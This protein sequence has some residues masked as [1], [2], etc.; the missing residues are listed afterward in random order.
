MASGY[1]FAPPPAA[2]TS[3]RRRRHEL[4]P[5][6]LSTTLS[7]IQRF[8][9]H[10]TGHTP[11][12]S[13]TPT[14]ASN[15][16]QP[17]NFVASPSAVVQSPVV[18]GG[19]YNPQQW[20]AATPTS[21]VAGPGYVPHNS[22]SVPV[23]RPVA[24]E[25][26]PPPPPYSPRRPGDR[27]NAPQS[28]AD[29]VSP[30][31]TASP[32]TNSSRYDTPISAST[33]V[34]VGS[35][36]YQQTLS[37]GQ[38]M[39][40]SALRNADSTPHPTPPPPPQA[41]LDIRA[42]SASRTMNDLQQ[43][44]PCVPA[45]NQPAFG[46]VPADAPYRANTVDAKYVVLSA[47]HVP[48]LTALSLTLSAYGIDN[49]SRPPASRRAASTGG[50]GGPY[51]P[52]RPRNDNG[53]PG[54]SGWE[55][56]MPLPPPPPGPPPGARSQSMSRTMDSPARDYSAPEAPSPHPTRRPPPIHGS[57]LP[58]V[59]PTPLDWREDDQRSRW[60]EQENPGNRLRLDT[61]H[62]VTAAA[63]VEQTPQSAAPGLARAKAV[64]DTHATGIRERR[65]ESR[66]GKSRMTEADA[67]VEG[68][69]NP[70]AGELD[71]DG[72]V[73]PTDLDLPVE[74]S[75]L[76][77]RQTVNRSTPRSARSLKLADGQPESARSLASAGPTDPGASNLPLR[78]G[79]ARQAKSPEP[80]VPTP[81]FSPGFGS[82]GTPSRPPPETLP[83]PPPQSNASLEVRP[84]G[85]ERPLSHI[86]HTPIDEPAVAAPLVPSRPTSRTSAHRPS[87]VFGQS[88]IERHQRFVEREA[89]A[90][91]DHE[92]VQ[93]FSDFIVA[94]SRIRRE[95]YA[96]AIDAMGSEILELTRDLFKPYAR[97]SAASPSSAAGSERSSNR[98][99]LNLA[100][101][102][103]FTPT[104]SPKPRVESAWAGVYMPSLSPIPSM[105]VSEAP[106]G[107]SSRG[108]PS[109]RWWEA[110]QEG[111]VSGGGTRG[112]ERSKRES[113]YMGLPLREWD[114][115]SSSG[116]STA[117]PSTQTVELPQEKSGWHDEETPHTADPRKLD[118]SRLVTLPPPYPRHYPAVNNNHPELTSIRTVV[119]ALTELGKVAATKE[120]FAADC[121]G[122]AATEKKRRSQLRE[123]MNR[124][125]EAGSLSY[126]DAA[127]IEEAEGNA[128]GAT[129]KDEFENYQT[130]VM[131][132][133]HAMLTERIATATE[134]FEQLRGHLV[135][136]NPME[137]GDEK[138]ELLEKLTLL[139]WIF[140]A[141]EQLHREAHDLLSERN[142]RYKR[143]VVAPYRAGGQAAKK[144]EVEDFF[145]KD[146]AERAR[147]FEA[148]ALGRCEAFM[149]VVEENVRK[150][151]EIQLSAFWDIAPALVEVLSRVDVERGVQTDG[152]RAYA[153]SQ[154]YLWEVLS[155][156]EK[157]AYQFIEGQVNLLCLLHEVKS[158]MNKQQGRVRALER[159]EAAARLAADGAEEE[160]RLTRDLKERV[161]MVE[162]QWAEAMGERVEEVKGQVRAWLMRHDGWEGLEDDD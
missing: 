103:A 70:W 134:S 73:R 81:P 107:Q 148:A 80:F 140:E 90:S 34:S 82:Q 104:E 39:S 88:A 65:S 30:S 59:P 49:P 16:Y 115:S 111:S 78:P 131:K 21:A 91:S 138:P 152:E 144:Q 129:L 127:R 75:M 41:P 79:S 110:S 29:T 38:H 155:H 43:P 19:Q 92:R 50:I 63:T 143:M 96:G 14:S 133:L 72:R 15:G 114:I 7:A 153:H 119:R 13:T 141:R 95:R 124:Q 35:T 10:L 161:G 97:T 116:T 109:S 69:N 117:G 24:A 87:D 160:E 25:G 158:G 112:L 18:G 113:K 156:A 105:S 27:Q 56:G 62:A 126:A 51:A 83:T 40:P 162:G 99:S 71:H 108:R 4:Q 118:V 159:P 98:G 84:L 17:A 1:A 53:P 6:A 102:E 20:G 76:K 44:T 33:T 68:S 101:H 132:P 54:Q 149:D 94:E 32:G 77:R 147:S 139:K 52:P 130:R 22:L 31:N 123:D 28:A 151:V 60:T 67:S 3:S 125:I 135:E 150:G 157:S 45:S 146:H 36:G 47:F 11:T 46:E 61:S 5:P 42:R 74:G 128:E 48:G 9:S 2:N 100:I 55:P 58:P 145:A 93:L 122:L 136:Q 37:P 64:R 57:T 154:Q 8:G 137:E 120:A 26:D 121:D 12:S 86:L 85:R 142:E 89:A 106:D 66:T 23:S